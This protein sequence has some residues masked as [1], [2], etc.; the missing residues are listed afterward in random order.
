MSDLKV[1]PGK[2]KAPKKPKDKLSSL[3]QHPDVQAKMGSIIASKP[4]LKEKIASLKADKMA[5]S[6][7][8]EKEVADRRAKMKLV[9]A[10]AVGYMLA[11]VKEQILAKAAFDR[12]ALARYLDQG[13]AEQGMSENER[14]AEIERILGAHD[15]GTSTPD[16]PPEGGPVSPS[17]AQ[18]TIPQDAPEKI[19]E[20]VE[21]MQAQGATPEAAGQMETQLKQD[22]AENQPARA[23]VIPAEKSPDHDPG[24]TSRKSIP[25]AEGPEDKPYGLTPGQL[26]SLEQEYNTHVPSKVMDAI[27]D[28]FRKQGK[29]LEE[30]KQHM[31]DHKDTYFTKR[32]AMINKSYVA[33]KEKAKEKAAT[34]KEKDYYKSILGEVTKGP[35]GVGQVFLGGATGMKPKD[36]QDPELRQQLLDFHEKHKIRGA[37]K[38]D[39]SYEPDK[40][41]IRYFH[42]AFDE[43]GEKEFGRMNHKKIH[44]NIMQWLKGGEL[45]PHLAMS[46]KGI[47]AGLGMAPDAPKEDDAAWDEAVRSH[48]ERKHP[49]PHPPK[50]TRPGDIAQA[51]KPMYATKPIRVVPK[52]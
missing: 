36:W 28:H 10:L 12:A 34:K 9:K 40:S 3:F 44:E 17:T 33:S 52:K 30:F 23:A 45:P 15:T 46:D 35:D 5:D 27:K 13:L 29:S 4:G 14:A 6:I 43:S 21:G 24:L 38:P 32:S 2:P 41:T 50:L 20:A 26:A 48:Y 25:R 49:D 31:K 11:A 16:K 47:A 37:R 39:G 18:P 51:P 7:T 42:P 8:S 22:L 1:L 19:P